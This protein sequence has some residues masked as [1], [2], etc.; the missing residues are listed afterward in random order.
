MGAGSWRKGEGGW[1]LGRG[2]LGMMGR[3]ARRVGPRQASPGTTAGK[4]SRCPARW[5]GNSIDSGPGPWTQEGAPYGAT[6]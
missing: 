2:E 6:L 3:V 4:K 1:G 5:Q